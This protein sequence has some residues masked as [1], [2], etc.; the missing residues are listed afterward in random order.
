[1]KDDFKEET[2]ELINSLDPDVVCFQEFYI[3]V[4]GKQQL[5]KI[6][7]QRANFEDYYFRPSIGN[8]YEG[9]GQA[10]FSKHPI[11]HSGSIIEHGFCINKIIFVDITLRDDTFLDHN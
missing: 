3:R 6:L 10:I 5:S 11:V 1:P 9:Y 4:R 8:E 2:I 7:K